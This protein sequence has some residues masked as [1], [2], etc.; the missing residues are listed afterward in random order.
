M[1]Q[2]LRQVSL[3]VKKVAPRGSL[4]EG[5]NNALES[6]S[7]VKTPGAAAV[8]NR[9]FRVAGVAGGIGALVGRQFDPRGKLQ[10]IVKMLN[11]RNRR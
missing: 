10:R 4:E 1:Q 5:T 11:C 7:A 8:K 2:A 6:N 3:Q 9:R